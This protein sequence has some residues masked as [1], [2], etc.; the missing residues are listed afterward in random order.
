MFSFDTTTWESKFATSVF[1][2]HYRTELCTFLTKAGF[3]FLISQTLVYAMYKTDRIDISVLVGITVAIWKTFDVLFFFCRKVRKPRAIICQMFYFCVSFIV[4]IGIGPLMLNLVFRESLEVTFASY[5]MLAFL[6]RSFQ[7]KNYAILIVTLSIAFTVHNF[8][9]VKEDIINMQTFVVESLMNLIF[10]G[11]LLSVIYNRE[12]RSRKIY[13][14]ERIIE[15]EIRRTEELL[16]KM[17]PEHALAGIK[18]DQKVIDS[19]ENVT[20]LSAHVQ[21]L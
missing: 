19:L 4:F 18:N 11:F 16:N 9:E 10:V 14:N 17:V 21:G 1:R 7:F 20:I 12:M 13:N 8:F 3:D 5:M 2:K 6:T 15:V